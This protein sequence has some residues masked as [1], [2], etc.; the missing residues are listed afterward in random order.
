LEQRKDKS[1]IKEVSEMEEAIAAKQQEITTVV[2]LY[3]EVI[4]IA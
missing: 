3:K 2:N 4:R 1:L